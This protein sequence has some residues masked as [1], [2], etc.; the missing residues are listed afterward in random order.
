VDPDD[1]LYVPLYAL[2]AYQ[3][4][5]HRAYREYVLGEWAHNALTVDA[6]IKHRRVEQGGRHMTQSGHR[7]TRRVPVKSERHRLMGVIDVVE[8]GDGHVVP[9]EY[10][11]GRAG[12]W[13]SDMVQLCAQALCLEEH[14]GRPVTHGYIWYMGSRQRC[15]VACG[16][17]LRQKTLQVATAVR[18]LLLGLEVPAAAYEP[19]RCDPCSLEPLCMPRTV[20]ALTGAAWRDDSS[21]PPRAGG[22]W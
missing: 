14:L 20:A 7:Q 22:V 17:E 3:Y 9:V 21:T 1:D 16:T 12:P 5:P 4:C 15:R 11:R 10:K 19:R 8:T 2:N 18:R 13:P 6:E